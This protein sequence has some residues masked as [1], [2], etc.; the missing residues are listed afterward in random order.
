MAKG[1][2]AVRIPLASE[3]IMVT[4]FERFFQGKRYIKG[5]TYKI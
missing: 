1:K 3:I 5:V 4:L 2:T